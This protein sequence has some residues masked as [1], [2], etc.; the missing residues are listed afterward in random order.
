M[1]TL[2]GDM[3]IETWRRG[4]LK[5]SVSTV[6][7]ITTTFPSAGAMIAASILMGRAIGPLEQIVGQWRSIVAARENWTSLTKALAS[8]P[9][10][11]AT[12]PLPPIRGK[13]AVIDIAIGEG[14]G[15]LPFSPSVA[16]NARIHV[17]VG[18]GQRAL[19]IHLA[20][21]PGP[22]IDQSIGQGQLALT[23]AQPL[24]QDQITANLRDSATAKSKEIEEEDLPF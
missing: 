4:P 1:C 24:P 21:R 5:Y 7:S 20:R 11:A 9:P 8:V 18:Q 16:E 6:S 15:A 14:E 3:K 23:V 13:A 17:A 12:M 10:P 22:V 2:M 19:A